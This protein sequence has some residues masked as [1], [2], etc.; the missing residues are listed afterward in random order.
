MAAANMLMASGDD[1]LKER[2]LPDLV[3][4]RFFGTMCLS[5]PHAGSSLANLRTTATPMGDG[6][7]QIR[8]SKM[9]ITGAEHELSENI[10]HF[11]LARLPDG[12]VGT[13]ESRSFSSP[14]F[15]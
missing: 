1:A 6:T 5:E 14:S 8:G 15:A 2:F 13:R 9:W 3:S 11:V 4:G 7:Y 10:I 12:G